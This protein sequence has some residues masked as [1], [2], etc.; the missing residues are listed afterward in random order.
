MI[1]AL[2]ALGEIVSRDRQ[3]ADDARRTLS[4]SAHTALRTADVTAVGGSSELSHVT[5]V[6]PAPIALATLEARFGPG[7][8]P[9][10]L[11]PDS[12]AECHF[13][14]PAP[15]G[16]THTWV[17]IAV[18]GPDDSVTELTVRRDPR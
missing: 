16:R 14:P 13:H 15:A 8:R 12:P 5:V 9:P 4:V 3:T 1:D 7:V 17:L 6:P 11:H 10:Q 18:L 2:I